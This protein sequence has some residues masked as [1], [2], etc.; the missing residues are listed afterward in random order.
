MTPQ[1]Q[2]KVKEVLDHRQKD[3]V[4]VLENIDDPHNIGAILRSCDAF[5]VLD[6][7]LLYTQG[8]APRLGEL[9]TKAAASALKW[10]RLTKWNSAAALIKY[11]KKKKMKIA[12]TSLRGRSRDVHS[13]DCIAPLAFVLGNEHTG[14]SLEMIKAADMNARIPMVGFVQSFNVSVAAAILLY[15]AYQQRE[16]VGKYLKASFNKIEQKKILKN[17]EK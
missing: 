3:L 17:W 16:K 14:V 5:G 9:K 6:V 12:V 1:R 13:V 7:H 15:E 4:V 10:L 2:K 11:L 8:R